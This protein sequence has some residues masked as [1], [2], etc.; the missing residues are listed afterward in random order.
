MY[1]RKRFEASDS[2]IAGIISFVDKNLLDHGVKKSDRIKPVLTVED[3]TASLIKHSRVVS[4]EENSDKNNYLDVTI[5]ASLGNLTIELS[6][7]GEEY[8][9]LDEVSSSMRETFEE[10]EDDAYLDAVRN[11]MQGYLKDNLKHKY[12]HGVNYI[13]LTAMRSRYGFLYQT[14]GAMAAAIILGL[15]FNA[16]MPGSVITS[17]NE[18]LLVPVRT[19]Y[20]NALKMIV[21]P[22]VFFSII[23]CVSQ[24]TDLKALGRIGGEV[25]SLYL[26]TTLMAVAAGIGLFFLI[27]PGEASVAGM[28]VADASAIT[29][30]TMKVSILD[31]IVGIIP[32]DII[33]PFANSDMLELIFMAVLFG[34]ATGY[35]GKYS[36]KLTDLFH[37]LNDLFLKVATMLIKFM[38]IAAFCSIMSMVITTG[39]KT[40]FSV[41]AMFGTFILGLACMMC[42][43]LLVMAVSCGVSPV[44]FIRAYTPY[45]LQTFSAASSNAAIPINLEGC[46]KLGVSKRISSL[47][48]PLGAT[49]NMNG[50]CVYMAV[51]ALSLARI[52]GIEITYGAMLSMIISIIVLSVGAPGIPGS[53]MICLSVLLTQMNVPVE[54]IGIVMGIDS[55]CCMCR[56]ASNSL[57]DVV[58][59]VIVGKKEG[60]LDKS[61]FQ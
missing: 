61:V 50:S 57:G 14:L 58:V 28:V 26:I 24:F 53:G 43:Y 16:F 49:I 11:I 5:S 45:F 18:F 27:R 25:L 13:G 3:V 12:S 15:L 46:E 7:P 29:S 8:S 44:Q 30:Q 33:H 20:M 41:L 17:V 51:F 59:S 60:G 32:S 47:V 48:I 10:D 1:I 23:S 38:P 39:A 37:A 6:A 36:E 4:G 2:D 42:I 21:A 54:A 31:M 9:I 55:L 40:M 19:M 22:V 34:T 35:L 52:Y 56:A